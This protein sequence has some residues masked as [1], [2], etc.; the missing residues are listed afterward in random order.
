M[1]K[2]QSAWRSKQVSYSMSSKFRRCS[3]LAKTSTED[4]SCFEI[5]HHNKK[6]FQVFRAL[7][8]RNA[9][10][11]V[12]IECAERQFPAHRLVLAGNCPF[13]L[14]KFVPSHSG[15]SNTETQSQRFLF[16]RDFKPS[17]VEAV[18]DL[19]YEGVLAWK[20]HFIW[21]LL[22]VLCFLEVRR[23]SCTL[24]IFHGDLLSQTCSCST[25]IVTSLHLTCCSR[26]LLLVRC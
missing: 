3:F 10:C 16:P 12:I 20:F 18:L 13:F 6:A 21:E 19:L 4:D 23:N 14:R 2:W 1:I 7:R 24:L 17:A 25:A 9:L 11:D 22:Q 8:E 5:M 26:Q 15:A